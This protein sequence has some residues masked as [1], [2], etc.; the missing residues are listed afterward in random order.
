M[1]VP[2]IQILSRGLIIPEVPSLN[3]KEHK[4]IL[5][6]VRLVKSHYSALFSICKL[7][8]TLSHDGMLGSLTYTAAAAALYRPFHLLVII[9][10][11]TTK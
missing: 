2:K 3:V 7:M 8:E 10:G 4:I 1:Y 9:Q 11:H 6:H 5:Y